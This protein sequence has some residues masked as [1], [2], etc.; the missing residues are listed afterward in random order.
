M[1]NQFLKEKLSQLLS[2][3]YERKVMFSKNIFYKASGFALEKL[4][5][6]KFRFEFL[7]T[8]GFEMNFFENQVSNPRVY[9]N[10][11]F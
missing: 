6:I 5:D 8:S 3:P 10:V 9:K 1:K 7:K 11:G 2:F 4:R